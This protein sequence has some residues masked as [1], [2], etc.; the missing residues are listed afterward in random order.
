MN[1][2]EVSDK[3]FD[4]NF[5]TVRKQIEECIKTTLVVQNKQSIDEAVKK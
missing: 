5:P 4:I 3:Y 1:Q 2:R